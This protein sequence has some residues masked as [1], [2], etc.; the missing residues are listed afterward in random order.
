L[1]REVINSLFQLAGRPI[2]AQ[3][4]NSVVKQA[5]KELSL[6]KYFNS[7]AVIKDYPDDLL[8]FNNRIASETSP[9]VKIGVEGHV[10]TSSYW[11]EAPGSVSNE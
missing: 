7:S 2:L 4:L 10:S 5:V 9:V 3:L 6:A 8:V 1:K 11:I